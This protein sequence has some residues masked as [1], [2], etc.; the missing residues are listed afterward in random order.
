[1]RATARLYH[2]REEYTVRVD[3]GIA[4]RA[5]AGFTL[6]EV[7]VAMVI[8]AVGL[9]GLEALGIGVARSVSLADRQSVY[10]VTAGDSLEAAL[11]LLRSGRHASSFC[12]SNALPD[13]TKLS[14][15]V[16]ASPPYLMT[17][18]VRA[19]PVVQAAHVPRDT[20]TIA[21]SAYVPDVAALSGS[22]SGSPC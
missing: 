10:A 14:R 22:P 7:L 6:I 11:R 15:A 8:L 20:F 4:P 9:L 12:V 13:G 16:V 1:M 2:Q 3:R 18:T 5:E 17:V 19:I 21:S